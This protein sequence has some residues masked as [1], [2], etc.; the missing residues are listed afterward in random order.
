MQLEP[1][2]FYET[3]THPITLI[4]GGI[5]IIG[6][7]MAGAKFIGEF[8]TILLIIGV[9]G[10]LMFLTGIVIVI[11]PSDRKPKLIVDETGIK[12]VR[13]SQTYPWHAI[14]SFDC[15]VNHSLI[16]LVIYHTLN[17]N[18]STDKIKIGDLE[19]GGMKVFTDIKAF[20]MQM[21]LQN[22]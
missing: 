8:Y 13:K 20:R 5:I 1:L 16:D 21:E 12:N 18:V 10:S 14:Q 3:R 22:P 15:Q 17:G 4:I 9:V 19:G 11:K 2:E 7:A 6:M